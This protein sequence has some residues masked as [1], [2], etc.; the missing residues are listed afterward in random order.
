MLVDSL[1]KEQGGDSVMHVARFYR[2]CDGYP[3]AFGMDICSA[4]ARASRNPFLNNRNWAQHFLAALCSKGI[5]IE[6]E[7]PDGP[8]AFSH[9]DIEY[10]YR[11][12]GV[13]D[14]SGG[15]VGM[16][17]T[18]DVSVAIYEVG[19]NQCGRMYD[20]LRDPIFE[21]NWK[22]LAR[23]LADNTGWSEWLDDPNLGKDDPE[24]W[25]LVREAAKA[26]RVEGA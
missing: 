4:L 7:P 6:M 11:V 15:K 3:D 9:S 18:D 22:G 24:T 13:T 20:E 1:F 17:G 2:H 26:P 14:L 5:D 10:A 12:T 19:F 8:D 16:D 21:G 23:W 25:D